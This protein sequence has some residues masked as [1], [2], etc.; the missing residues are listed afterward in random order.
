MYLLYLHAFVLRVLRGSAFTLRL[1][2]R[3]WFFAQQ[4]AVSRLPR[5]CN[6]PPHYTTCTF[7]CRYVR[8]RILISRRVVR[9]WLRC[10]YPLPTR[11]YLL[12]FTRLPCP[13][14]HGYFVF[15]ALLVTT[16][17]RGLPLPYTAA[18][19]FACYACTTAPRCPTYLYCCAVPPRSFTRCAFTDLSLC[20]ALRTLHAS[21]HSLHS[22]LFAFS[23]SLSQLPALLQRARLHVRSRCTRLIFVAILHVVAFTFTF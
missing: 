10:R 21:P 6:A 2:L 13:H 18:R 23:L 11:T 12:R 17:V 22:S 16:H 14:Y 4:F 20:V 3:S 7:A 15:Y 9:A 5:G 8:A 1:R 19:T